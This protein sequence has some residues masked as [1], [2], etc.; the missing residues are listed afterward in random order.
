MGS[1]TRYE[2]DSI[3]WDRTF[4]N[5]PLKLWTTYNISLSCLFVHKKFKFS[6]INGQKNI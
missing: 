1:C 2:M 3:F 6:I 5:F 4:K